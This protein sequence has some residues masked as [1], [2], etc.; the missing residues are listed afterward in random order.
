MSSAAPRCLP[1]PAESPE[2][3]QVWGKASPSGWHKTRFIVAGNLGQR[4]SLLPCRIPAV[5]GTVAVGVNWW[6]LSL[7]CSPDL[8][9]RWHFPQVLLLGVPRKCC[10]CS[11]F[12][13]CSLESPFICPPLCPAAVT[14]GSQG[15]QHPSLSQFAEPNLSIES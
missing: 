6:L 11:P 1:H 14:E 12:S 5:T 10:L 9:L 7:C 8:W 3:A 4:G 2:C 15:W 13:P